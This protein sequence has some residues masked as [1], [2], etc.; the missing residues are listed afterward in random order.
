[1]YVRL[2]KPRQDQFPSHLEPLAGCRV[3]PRGKLTDTPVLNG[4]ILL[5][6]GNNT[7][8]HNQIV[9]ASSCYSPSLQTLPPHAGIV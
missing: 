2:H 6:P 8:L 9:H 3:Q 5:L 4:D 7:A 1:M